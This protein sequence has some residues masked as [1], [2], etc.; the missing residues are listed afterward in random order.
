[1]T[2]S[3]PVV[4]L[5]HG[6][7][8]SGL[9]MRLLGWRLHRCGFT[10]RYF[11]YASLRQTPKQ[12]ALRLEKYLAQ[13]ESPTVH[14][15]AHSLGGIVLAHLLSFFPPKQPGRVVMLA[16]PLKGSATARYLS[17]RRLLRWFLGRSVVKGLFGDIPGEHA[18]RQVGMLAGTRGIGIGN[19]L[20]HGK[21]SKPNDGTVAVNETHSPLINEHRTV[22][23]SHMGILFSSNA[24][25]QVCHYLKYGCFKGN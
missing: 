11:R 7:W 16:S 9:E 15:V 8:M 24:A 2:A 6:I 4:V 20:A 17:H 14:L 21:L 12:N 3:S 10:C 19:I 23:Y 25:M 22:P 18:G 13:I 5:I 1:M